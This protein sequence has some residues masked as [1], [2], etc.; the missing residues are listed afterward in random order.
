MASIARNSR[1]AL[2]IWLSRVHDE[3]TILDWLLPSSGVAS[4]LIAGIVM[5]MFAMFKS[6][7]GG[8]G[9]FFPTKMIAATVFGV[10]ALIGSSGVIFT[11]LMIHMMMSAIFGVI[12]AF[13]ATRLNMGTAL[14]SGVAYGAIL[15]A[16]MTFIGLPLVNPTMAARVALMP[17]PW[18]VNHLIFGGMLFLTP[19]LYRAFPGRRQSER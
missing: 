13:L 7:I 6:F 4:G 9:F 2:R 16:G 17:V 10:D 3:A 18:F 8:T 15:W 19:T 5:A 11:G 12:F 1:F 14:V